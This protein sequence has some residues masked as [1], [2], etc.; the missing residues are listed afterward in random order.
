MWHDEK[1]EGAIAVSIEAGC[2]TARSTVP[3]TVVA[4]VA[5]ATIGVRLAAGRP[6]DREW[7]AHR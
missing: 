6:C 4:R 2:R 5:A 7:G 1:G 3:V